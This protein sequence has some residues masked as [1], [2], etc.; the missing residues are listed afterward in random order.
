MG[1]QTRPNLAA[2]KESNRRTFDEM[3]LVHPG[4]SFFGLVR[5]AVNRLFLVGLGAFGGAKHRARASL[6]LRIRRS[7]HILRDG[8]QTIPASF[9]S[10]ENAR[11]CKRAS[12]RA[13]NKP[14][15]AARSGPSLL[16]AIQKRL[17]KLRFQGVKTVNTAV[18]CQLFQS[19]EKQIVSRV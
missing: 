1:R 3:S 15:I 5:T 14:R 7:R 19:L 9:C 18:S 13:R 4:E 11:L 16:F 12:P 2:I 10:K 6:W 17:K 8:Q